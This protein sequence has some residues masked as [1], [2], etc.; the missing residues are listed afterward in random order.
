MEV[1]AQ[2]GIIFKN[3]YCKDYL[4]TLRNALVTLKGKVCIQYIY[5][6]QAQLHHL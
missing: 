4:V 5:R 3:T 6:L 1:Y 2:L